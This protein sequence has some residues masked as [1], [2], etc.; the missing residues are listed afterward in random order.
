MK[1]LQYCSTPSFDLKAHVNAHL[2]Y[3]RFA[4]LKYSGG[5]LLRTQPVL[6]PTS[7][8]LDRIAFWDIMGREDGSTATSEG[9][10]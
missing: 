8:G 6:V 10:I 5:K 2:T 9:V 1:P 7:T 3:R 4:I